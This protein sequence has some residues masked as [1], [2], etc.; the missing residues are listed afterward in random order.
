MRPYLAPTYVF[1]ISVLTLT[2]AL[3]WEFLPVGPDETAVIWTGRQVAAGR[4]PY[5]D[6]LD[7][8]PPLGVYGAGAYALFA[9]AGLTP[10][11][12]LMLGWLTVVTLVFYGLARSA[13]VPRPWAL[14]GALLV[15]GLFVPFWPATSYH[16]F[17]MGLGLIGILV[18]GVPRPASSSWFFAGACAGMAGLVVQTE[19]AWFLALLLLRVF[20]FRTEGRWGL[21]ATVVGGALVPVAAFAAA[22]YGQG[23]LRAA[24]E[25]VVLW[26][27]KYYRQPGGENDPGALEFTVVPSGH[28]ET[29]VTGLLS[30]IVA[31]SVPLVLIGML[32]TSPYVRNREGDLRGSWLLGVLGTVLA[33]VLF[34]IGRPDW[35]HLV[36]WLTPL[37]FLLL[38]ETDW[39]AKTVRTRVMK[40]WLLVAV[41]VV[42]V[43]WTMYWRETPPNAWGIIVLDPAFRRN[44]LPSLVDEIPGA[45]EYR[46]PILYLDRSASGLYLYWSPSWPPVTW[47]L[48]PSLP[49]NSP[50][51]YEA[52]VA[53]A[54]E[55]RVPWIVI[56]YWS[57][58]SFTTDESPVRA[59]LSER[60]RAE[61]RTTWGRAF[62]RIR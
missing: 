46:Q 34:L 57:V 58:E 30:F 40:G 54:I 3:S 16:W 56:P 35:T 33:L 12:F 28:I 42:G 14:A 41:L 44:S 53:F 25:A 6:F 17:A 37:L 31:A 5:R 60:Y 29:D 18:V 59:L 55:Q 20:L 62:A 15:P 47:V 10:F 2:S 11:R 9:G 45:R 22:L 27:A 8:P 26:P 52:L 13:A 50:D 23:T 39:S 19:G 32:A 7:F 1:V 21:A 43:R 36:F 48:P 49:Y 38:R 61:H 51:Q 24:F 4:V